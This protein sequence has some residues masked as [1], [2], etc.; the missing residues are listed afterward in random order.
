M[1]MADAVTSGPI[2]AADHH[3]Y[4]NMRCWAVAD[5]DTTVCVT[6]AAVTAGGVA[7]ID[8]ADVMDMGCRHHYTVPHSMCI[9]QMYVCDSK[10]KCAVSRSDP[11]Q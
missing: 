5:I 10:G 1:Q 11:R 4:A 7:V 8:V 3:H 2:R 9:M 6:A